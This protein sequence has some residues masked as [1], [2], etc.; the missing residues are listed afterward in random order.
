MGVALGVSPEKL[1]IVV[2][3]ASEN[4][5]IGDFSNLERYGIKNLSGKMLKFSAMPEDEDG[6]SVTAISA[7]R[8][9][10]AFSRPARFLGDKAFFAAVKGRHQIKPCWRTECRSKP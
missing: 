9:C 4:A 7:D 10:R 1:C 2:K 6:R 5:D 8:P 3:S